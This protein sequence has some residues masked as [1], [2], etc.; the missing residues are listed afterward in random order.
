MNKVDVLVLNPGSKQTKNVVRDLVYGC[1]CKGKRIGGMKSPPLNLLYIATIL[2]EN[3]HNVSFIDALAMGLPFGKLI[4]YIKKSEAVII[5]TSTMSFSEDT[6]LLEKCKKINPKIKTVIFGSH[7]TFMPQDCLS[8]KSVDIIVRKEPEF[9]I[10]DLFNKLEKSGSVWKKVKGIGYRTK[11]S[12]IIINQDYGFGD[13]NELP[14]PDR[15][16]L[17]KNVDYFNPLIKK[18]PYTTIIT[19]RGCPAQCTFCTVPTFYGNSIRARDK[20][21]V[22]KEL[23]QIKKQGYKEFWI[24]DET[25]TIYKKRNQ[26]ICKEMIKRNLNLSWLCNA[27]VGTVDK[28]TMKLMKRAGCHMIKFGVESG[29]QRILDNVKKGISVKKTRE[30]FRWAHEVG[31]D[32]HAHMMLGM[33]GETKKTIEKS[34][35]FA[36]LIDPTTV[37]FGICTPY[38]GTPLYY[39]VLKENSK[40]NDGSACDLSE[41][42]EKAFFNEYFTSLG[43][44]QLEKYVR[45]AYRKF[46]LRPSYIFK[47][48]KRINNLEEFR[49]VI[50]AGSN[51]FSFIF[52]KK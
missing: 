51:V 49:R 27:R 25:F 16:F 37:S 12:K 17:P 42:H 45:K 52:E 39:K 28:E 24:R 8:K 43:K 46:Y 13:I 19:S 9:I 36:K 18:V 48:L 47:Y 40:I 21:L 14:I 23:E 15:N 38:A 50:L 34:I 2:K 31:M 22:I 3:K 5:N 4:P 33:P 44:D 1:W 7:P 32:T 6:L 26:E 41:L 30:T 20:D 29:V 10:R 35:N 11:G